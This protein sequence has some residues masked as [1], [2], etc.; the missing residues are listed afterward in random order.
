MLAL[1]IT[2]LAEQIM[3][4]DNFT[5]V[6]ILGIPLVFLS[7]VYVG[8]TWGLSASMVNYRLDNE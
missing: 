8:L 7:M 5:K 1:S 6:R 3:P 4:G 2:I